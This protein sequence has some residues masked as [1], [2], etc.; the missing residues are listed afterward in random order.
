MQAGIRW[1]CAEAEEIAKRVWVGELCSISQ[2]AKI[3]R[4]SREFL[5]ARTYCGP[6]LQE[7]QETDSF[8]AFVLELSGTPHQEGMTALVETR[9]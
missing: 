9:G 8:K 3:T 5:R 4:F 1:R 2:I 7:L 6:E